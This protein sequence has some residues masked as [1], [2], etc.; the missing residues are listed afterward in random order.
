M[1]GYLSVKSSGRHGSLSDA[2]AVGSS[3]LV[4]GAILAIHH[5]ELTWTKAVAIRTPVPK[6][7]QKKKIFGGIFIHLTFFATTGKPQP[8]I[9]AKKTM[10]V[11]MLA[12][13]SIA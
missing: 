3:C 1:A 9:D 2:K 5:S 6:C 13:L 8:P 12:D 11:L 7:L 10:T 4:S